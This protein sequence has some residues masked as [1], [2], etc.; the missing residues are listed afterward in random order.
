MSEPGQGEEP[1]A[2]K[3][4]MSNLPQM[5]LPKMPSLPKIPNLPGLLGKPSSEFGDQ[6]LRECIMPPT[7]VK[8]IPNI[9]ENT[10]KYYSDVK[11]ALDTDVIKPYEDLGPDLPLILAYGFQQFFAKNE[12]YKEFVCTCVANSVA[13]NMGY[14]IETNSKSFHDLLNGVQR[15]GSTCDGSPPFDFKSLIPGFGLGN[16]ALS[17]TGTISEESAPPPDAGKKVADYKASVADALK[18]SM[19]KR[20]SKEVNGATFYQIN[21]HIEYLLYTIYSL[22]NE[23]YPHTDEIRKLVNKDINQTMA[24][25]ILKYIEDVQKGGDPGD[26]PAKSKGFSFSG[27]ADSLKNKAAELKNAANQ[28][29]AELK[30]K[31]NQKMTSLGDKLTSAK[32]RATQGATS[33]IKNPIGSIKKALT[34]KPSVDCKSA[35]EFVAEYYGSTYNYSKIVSDVD[36]YVGQSINKILCGHKE[37]LMDLC[38]KVVKYHL[39]EYLKEVEKDGPLFKFTKEAYIYCIA[40]FCQQL[41]EDIAFKMIYKYMFTENLN[42]FSTNFLTSDFEFINL[43]KANIPFENVQFEFASTPLNISIQNPDIKQSSKESAQLKYTFDPA[44]FNKEV[45]IPLAETISGL[46]KT[47]TGTSVSYGVTR[48]LPTLVFKHLVEVTNTGIAKQEVISEI[49]KIFNESIYRS[50]AAVNTQFQKDIGNGVIM[51]IMCKYLISKHTIT[52]KLIENAIK[53]YNDMYKIVTAGNKNE[54]YVNELNNLKG[55]YIY[56][57]FRHMLD[58]TLDQTHFNDIYSDYMNQ[59]P[60]PTATDTKPIP[61]KW[62]DHPLSWI[63]TGPLTNFHT[64]L[65][66][67]VGKPYSQKWVSEYKLFGGRKTRRLKHPILKKRRKTRRPRKPVGRRFSRKLSNK[68]KYTR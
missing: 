64:A 61:D 40:K 66:A 53:A 44:D 12:R 2:K 51:K 46:I 5:S 63:F 28:K 17:T 49:F 10:Q 20:F 55:F 34:V 50:V 16:Y 27:L 67:I 4:F 21:S 52:S 36:K 7:N 29:A 19:V 14:V 39:Y 65:L 11:P 24:G 54:K 37:T 25:A 1:P 3:G 58:R 38:N 23:Q 60:K 47:A 68:K 42:E 13:I 31:A 22:Y 45:K 48:A 26:P 57:S 43:A 33:F 9:D 35:N 56:H 8:S 41:P 6:S 15:G 62:T 18:N 59:M 30:N 32:E